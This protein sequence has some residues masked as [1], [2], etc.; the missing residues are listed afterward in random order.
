MELSRDVIEAIVGPMEVGGQSGETPEGCQ[1][2]DGRSP[3]CGSVTIYDLW[4]GQ[5]GEA[6]PVGLRDI[7]PGGLCVLQYEEMM[8]GQTFIVELAVP[9]A[10]TLRVVCQVKYCH[11]VNEDLLA[12]GAAFVSVW[13]GAV[14][15][16][17]AA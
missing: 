8:A 16:T 10:Q 3:L 1:R 2:R 11:S 4:R 6:K 9:G 7:S 15:K 5:V 17:A 14:T 12:I 13:T